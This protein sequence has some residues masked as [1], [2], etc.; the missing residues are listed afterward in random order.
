MRKAEKNNLPQGWTDTTLG[1][2]GEYLNG[3]AFK[4]HE[5]GNKGRPIIRIQDLTGTGKEPNY[6]DGE[7]DERYV[8]RHGDFLISWSATLGAYLWKGPEGVLNQHI[9]KVI[10]K[11][12]RLFHYYVVSNTINEL[13][14][15]THGSGMVHITKAKFEAV[16]VK[17]PPL[18]E[19]KRI[20]AKI[21]QLFSDL[22]AGVETLHALKKQ[23]KQYRQ[24]VLKHAFEGKLTAQWRKNNKPEPASKLLAKIAKEKEQKSKGKKQKKLPPLDT[25]DLPK[26]PKNWS[27][28]K[29]IDLLSLDRTGLKT[30]PFGSLLKKHE[31]RSS[32]VPV[33]GIENIGKMMFVPENKIYITKKKAEQLSGY[34]VLAGDIII[35]RSGTVGEICVVPETV[36]D[37]MISTNLMRVSLNPSIMLPIFFGFMFHG[38]SMILRQV[39]E[40]CKGSTRDFLNQNILKSLVFPLPSPDE[41]M[42]IISEIDRHFS[43]A[44]KAEYVVDTALKQSARLRQSILKRAFEGKLVT[45]DPNDEPAEKLLERVRKEKGKK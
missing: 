28:A 1:N 44:D 38:C 21:E 23:I 9:F 5:W 39:K 43:I 41:Q 19:Q 2:I 35:S 20:V 27:Y 6:F 11:I 31:H 30:G 14:R 40:L 18:N 26:L 4:K 8:I 29:I 34:R 13:Y 25:S 15:H 10:S 17:L 24:S 33:L 36:N 37:A 45:Q 42:Q 12:D 3:R 32:G 16:P 7:V 22:D